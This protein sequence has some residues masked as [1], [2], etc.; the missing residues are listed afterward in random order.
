MLHVLRELSVV[1]ERCISFVMSMLYA[2]WMYVFVCVCFVFFF[3]LFYFVLFLFVFFSFFFP[4]ELR[5][6]C[7]VCFLV[8]MRTLSLLCVV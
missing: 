5:D 4:G 8:G 3:F 7:G 1:F 6:A 2:N